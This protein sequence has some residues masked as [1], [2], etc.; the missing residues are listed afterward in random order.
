DGS[1]HPELVAAAAKVDAQ[2]KALAA[3]EANLKK[4]WNQTALAVG[5]AIGELFPDSRWKS[6]TFRGWA[7]WGTLAYGIGSMTQVVVTGRYH[8][9]ARTDTPGD[10]SLVGGRVIVGNASFTGFGELAWNWL[11]P[12]NELTL[13]KDN[14]GQAT[15]G[16]EIKLGD[17]TWL[18]ASFGGTLEKSDQQNDF[19]A[20]S[21]FKWSF[22]D[23]TMAIGP[24]R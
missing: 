13:P 5:G 7:G 24:L 2:H 14:W 1:A 22:G 4:K 20:A 21:N 11:K 10:T 9:A 19:F 18:V 16:F 3:A 8:S 17:K 12:E 23:K 15:L 6:H